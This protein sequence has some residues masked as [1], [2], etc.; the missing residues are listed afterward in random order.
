VLARSYGPLPA[1]HVSA[2]QPSWVFADEIV[3]D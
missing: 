1:G 3:M 2:G